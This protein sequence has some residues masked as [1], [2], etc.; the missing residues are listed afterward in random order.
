MKQVQLTGRQFVSS[1]MDTRPHL[2]GKNRHTISF[3]EHRDYIGRPI[4]W[5]SQWT[6]SYC[7][8]PKRSRIS[9]PNHSTSSSPPL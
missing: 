5:G 7:R 2:Q 9:I 6:A 4:K 1:S 8:I 3:Y